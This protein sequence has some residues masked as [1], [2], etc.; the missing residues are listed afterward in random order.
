MK[1][2]QPM[3]AAFLIGLIAGAIVLGFVDSYRHK[4]T[5]TQN[6]VKN[7]VKQTK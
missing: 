4:M 6:K 3:I 5:T 7:Q 2:T 1:I